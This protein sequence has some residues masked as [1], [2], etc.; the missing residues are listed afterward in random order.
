MST[1]AKKLIRANQRRHS[2]TLDLGYCGLTDLNQVP[3][4]F[5]STH[6]ETLIL[7]DE[8]WERDEDDK[9]SWFESQNKHEPG[10]QENPISN[11]ISSLPSGLLRLKN[12]KRLVVSS[13]KIST[14]ENLPQK[15]SKLDIGGNQISTL[16]NLPQKLSEL[17]IGGNQISTLQNLPQKL[18]ELDISGNQISTLENLPQN[19]SE[20]NI[21]SN[22]IS[23]LQNLPR[24]LSELVINNNQISTLENFPQKLSKLVIYDNQISSLQNLPQNLSKLDIS[25]NKISTLENLPQN[26][27]QLD[28]SHNQISKIEN[29]PQNLSELNIGSNKISTL[30]NLPQNL[31]KLNINYNQISKIENLPQKLS[32]L[33][34][35]GNQIS[36]LQNL[37]QNLS[38]LDISD[39]QI[40]K[41]E[42]LPQK[43]SE[44]YM[45]GNPLAKQYDLELEYGENHLEVIKNLLDKEAAGGL[46]DTQLPLK[47]LLLG[48]HGAGKSSLLHYLLE[49]DLAS[50]TE[51]TH[52]LNIAHYT[53]Q[54]VSELP[55]KLP[56]AI[57]FDFGGQDYYHGLH[58]L[59]F[60][61]EALYL[62]LWH[63]KSNHN[64]LD[65][66]SSGEIKNYYF[67]LNYWLGQRRY[68]DET[69]NREGRNSRDN[70]DNQ[71]A[72]TKIKIN[73]KAS[74]EEKK[75]EK[76]KKVNLIIQTHIDQAQVQLP[77]ITQQVTQPESFKYFRHFHLA[78][79][80]EF[81]PNSNEERHKSNP[82]F[83]QAVNQAG[84]EYFKA[85]LDE[86]INKRDS[87]KKTQQDL[88][89]YLNILRM[90]QENDV[91]SDKDPNLNPNPNPNSNLSAIGYRDISD[92]G[93]SRVNSDSEEVLEEVLGAAYFKEQL[94]QLEAEDISYKNGE[95]LISKKF[96]NKVKRIEQTE[97]QSQAQRHVKYF[98]LDLIDLHRKGLILYYPNINPFKAWVNPKKVI[99]LLHDTVFE[100]GPTLKM[101][102]GVLEAESLKK[103]LAEKLGESTIKTAIKATSRAT[104]E[105]L[106]QVLEEEEL[107]FLDEYSNKAEPKYIIPNFLPT[108][109]DEAEKEKYALMTFGLVRP[110]FTLKFGHFI[111]S[112]VIN[113]VICYFGKEPDKKEFWRNQ[114]VF[115]FDKRF[116]VLIHLDYINLEIKVFTQKVEPEVEPAV[117][118]QTSMRE[119]EIMDFQRFL[120]ICLA[121]FYLGEYPDEAHRPDKTDRFDS[122]DR[123]DKDRKKD[124]KNP[125]PYKDKK[126]DRK[127]LEKNLFTR[128][129]QR[130][131]DLYVSLDDARF[132]K[133]SDLLEAR[134]QYALVYYEALRGEK[135]KNKEQ[136]NE[137]QLSKSTLP[138]KP[139]QFCS[140]HALKST[141]KVFISYS[142]NDYH[143]LEEFK[144]FLAQP[145]RDKAIEVWT[146]QRLLVGNEWD[147]KIRKTLEEADIIC[148]LLSQDLINTSYVHEVEF[149]RAME[150]AER[151]QATIFGILLKECDWPNWKPTCN[152]DGKTKFKENK[153]DVPKEEVPLSKYNIAPKNNVT[154]EGNKKLTAIENWE[155]PAEAWMEVLKNLREVLNAE[156]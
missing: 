126:E 9:Y 46:K 63:E 102:K 59:F 81:G 91:D 37:P 17:D 23:T 7:S 90:Q 123:T 105:D 50:Q 18:S 30:Q 36:T 138:V 55:N 54:K 64:H 83:S 114:I 87:Y 76:L 146:D 49:G 69:L 45:Y 32:E 101:S 78:L 136:K 137:L 103:R 84:L 152:D 77:E 16:Q 53:A 125:T 95:V 144:K 110:S 124:T 40:S 10:D 139:F 85:V 11:N 2:P 108:T 141:K 19:L 8:W 12:L 60:N 150:K 96:I 28:I 41:I 82:D 73:R 140:P 118:K 148:L 48:N 70:Q 72:S 44:L 38:E 39:N 51:S 131:A 86:F 100:K 88:D 61:R 75:Q 155:Y 31:S 116:K 94:G 15:L 93:Y 151:N 24:N 42:N 62:F 22:K 111:P 52:L 120:F 21:G 71:D 121:N 98:I 20:L 142:K 134:E 156:S 33:D 74:K 27:S 43:L 99:E 34:I 145:L 29:L 65:L 25:Y 112:S 143:H 133:Y 113:R 66:E 79:N 104:S 97:A 67:D 132:I 6:L 147:E 128:L 56:E 119:I 80:K 68:L 1:L 3:E 127:E 149:K 5:D 57:F 129:N 13:N 106:L 154:P 4:L 115:T 58:R 117:D 130:C 92:L 35:S 107:I 122:P 26:L 153:E 109:E 14:L 89:F 47:V 135:Q